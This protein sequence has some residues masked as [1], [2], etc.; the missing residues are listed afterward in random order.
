MNKKI[1]N[2]LLITGWLIA[3]AAMSFLFYQSNSTKKVGYVEVAKLYNEFTLKKEL[4]N[5]LSS[6]LNKRQLILDSLKLQLQMQAN[7]FKKQKS[8]SDG[9]IREWERVKYEYQTS[10]KQFSEDNIALN[11]R[12][13]QQVWEQL[14]QY[15]KDY[16]KQNHFDYIHGANGSGTLLYAHEKNDITNEL[17]QYVNERYQ[18]V[19]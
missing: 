9:E 14:N 11:E 19:K 4:E 3:L 13:M 15:I 2:I 17:I 5:N 7:Y 10:E 16:G 18:G 6:I 12:Y 8:P 1:K